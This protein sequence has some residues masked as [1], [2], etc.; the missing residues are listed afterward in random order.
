M[1]CFTRR[2]ST[3]NWIT[4]RQ[5]RS[6]CTTT[7][8]MFRC[9]NTS[10]GGRPMIWLA[11]TRESEQPIHRYSGACWSASRVKNSGSSASWRLTHASL[12]A[13]RCESGLSWVFIDVDSVG[14]SR[15]DGARGRAA[16]PV[17]Q[18]AR[19]AAPAP[20]SWSGVASKRAA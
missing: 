16:S 12:L 13:K 17:R 9:T 2:M 11:G 10:P 5:F 4:D 14:G 19:C 20:S 7:F 15:G 18:A 1:M 3:A 8:A 6:L